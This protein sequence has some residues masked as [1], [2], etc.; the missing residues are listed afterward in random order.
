MLRNLTIS[1]KA[2][3]LFSMSIEQRPM[4][5]TH[6]PI[7]ALKGQEQM[8]YRLTPFQGLQWLGSPITGRCPVLMILPLQSFGYGMFEIH[9]Y[10]NHYMLFFSRA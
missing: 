8:L 5:G 3:S 2:E 1:K 9:Y 7:Q 10:E 4:K 6:A